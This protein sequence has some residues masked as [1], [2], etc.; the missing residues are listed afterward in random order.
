MEIAERSTWSCRK[1]ALQAEGTAG[2]KVLRQ[3][4]ACGSK[5]SPEASVAKRERIRKEKR[6]EKKQRAG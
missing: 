6:P 3:E 2:A 4:C 5:N 1:R